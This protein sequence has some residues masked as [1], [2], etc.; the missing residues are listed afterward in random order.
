MSETS[1]RDFVDLA[2]PKAWAARIEALEATVA[3]RTRQGAAVLSRHAI[4]LVI[5]RLLRAPERMTS[6]AAREIAELAGLFVPAERS[7]S[8]AGRERLR[9]RLAASLVGDN[10]LTPLFHQMRV[11][12]RHRRRG[13]SVAFSGFEEDTAFDLTITRGRASAELV[14]DVVS[15]DGGRGV[16]REA[17]RQLADRID[18]DLQTWLAA[19]PGRYLLKIT[20]PQG[21]RAEL[22]QETATLAALHR[23]IRAMLA[24][25]IRADHD[26]AAMLRL[27]PLL[28]AAAQAGEQG[29]L[30]Q[31]RREFGP[32]AHL[33]VTVAGKGVFVVA[34]RA[35]CEDDV[36]AMVG[37]RMSELSHKHLSGERPGILAM[38][39]ED[40]DLA[41]WR[42]LREHLHLEG[43][44]RRFLL[45]PEARP[46]VAV[47]C[48]T[49]A[50]LVGLA[51]PQAAAQGELRYANPAHPAASTA[52]L[53]SAVSSM[54]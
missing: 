4:E 25:Q 34:A 54:S 3:L 40:T 53:A 26:E 24:R 32:E 48:A 36:A 12:E 23:R 19:H 31:L 39:L 49:R 14:C 1:L 37:R 44:T 45:S 27:D 29:L 28:L 8:R 43:A 17:W 10:A 16:P 51:A 52:A 2:G 5:A 50:E 20:L 21:L 22:G 6:P 35:A 38:F 30:A 42:A 41:E 46:V 11:A 18:P 7:L 33:S 47:S 15:A 9:A 13:F